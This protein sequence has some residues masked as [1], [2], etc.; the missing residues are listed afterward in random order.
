MAHSE[1]R[2][3]NLIWSS[4]SNRVTRPQSPSIAG[5]LWPH[6]HTSRTYVRTLFKDSQE[7]TDVRTTTKTSRLNPASTKPRC[8]P[9]RRTRH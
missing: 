2:L 5:S 1:E 3:P 7:E 6:S 9:Q 8:F 4:G